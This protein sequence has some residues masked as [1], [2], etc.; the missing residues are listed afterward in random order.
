MVFKISSMGIACTVATVLLFTCANGANHQRSRE[1]SFKDVGIMANTDKVRDHEYHN[2][3]EKYLQPLRHRPVRLLE[4][5]L[6]CDML[7]G[8][9]HSLAL[10]THYFT[11]K[12]SSVSFVEY[13]AK[14]AEKYRSIIQAVGH[15]SLYVGDQAEDAFL[16][17]IVA[18]ETLSPFDIII[19]DGAVG[20]RHIYFIITAFW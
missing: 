4:I 12:N 10:W 13:D 11:H 6:G 3:Y 17:S 14:C 20:D 8:P 18:A 2:L 15:G 1:T 16:Q 19:D 5:G 7:Y 9:G